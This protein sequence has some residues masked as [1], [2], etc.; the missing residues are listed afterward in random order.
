MWAEYRA[1][2]YSRLVFTNT[3]SVL[4]TAALAAAMGD[5]PVVTAVLLRASDAFA[6]ERLARRES[7]ESLDRH[8]ARSRAAAVRLDAEAG[9]EVHRLDTDRLTPAEVA[10]RLLALTG[11]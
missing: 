5:D 2:G 11:W 7:G 4:E 6:S 10:E 1:L 8:V 9:S 3:V